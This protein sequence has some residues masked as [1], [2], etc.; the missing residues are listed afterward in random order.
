MARVQR[1]AP[2]LWYESEA[3]E[4]ARFYCSVFPNSSIGTIARYGEAGFEF[5]G[6]PAGSVMVVNFALDGQ[7]FMAMNGGPMF[8]FNEAVSLAVRCDTPQELDHY[9]NALAAGGEPAAQQCGWLKDRW[10]LSWQVVPGPLEQWM[11]SPRAEAVMTALLPMTK[12]DW[13]VLERAA[14]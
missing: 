7:P 9:W 4:A 2:C 10:G 14:R 8:K 6:R 13:S 11:A 12:L 1:I 3:E 5:H